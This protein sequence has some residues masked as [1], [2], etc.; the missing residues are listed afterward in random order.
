MLPINCCKR[1]TKNQ[2]KKSAKAETVPAYPPDPPRGSITEGLDIVPA[3]NALVREGM[4][5]QYHWLAEAMRGKSVWPSPSSWEGMGIA[6]LWKGFETEQ[7]AVNSTPQLPPTYLRTVRVW[8]GMTDRP[9]TNTTNKVHIATG[10]ED[11]QYPGA[12]PTTADLARHQFPELGIPELGTEEHFGRWA[13]EFAA[14]VTVCVDRFKEHDELPNE[15]TRLIAALRTFEVGTAEGAGLIL[16]LRGKAKGQGI[17]ATM[18]D[19]K[20]RLL[21]RLEGIAADLSVTDFKPTSIIRQLIYE[22]KQLDTRATK[23][24]ALLNDNLNRPNPTAFVEFIRGEVLRWKQDAASTRPKPTPMEHLIALHGL[25]QDAR[26]SVEPWLVDKCERWLASE[27]EEVPPS[28]FAQLWGQGN[29]DKLLL[30]MNSEGIAYVTDGKGGKERIMAAFH[31]GAEKFGHP[32]RLM[33]WQGLLQSHYPGRKISDK[34]RPK[35]LDTAGERYKG[36]YSAIMRRLT[37]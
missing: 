3:F 29:L 37:D 18:N 24:D 13:E 35:D 23:V 2:R 16:E 34:V 36:A 32:P 12:F 9:S 4:A 6:S 5:A 30:A 17:L 21:H 26:V 25:G 20:T 33:D 31:A 22:S 15:L 7:G 19:G 28:T 11:E 27:D 8:I 10:P 1:M 14:E